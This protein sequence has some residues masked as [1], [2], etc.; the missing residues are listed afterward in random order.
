MVVSK[1]LGPGPTAERNLSGRKR[2][3]CL[4]VKD[5]VRF[6]LNVFIREYFDGKDMPAID[7]RL[8]HRINN[9]HMQALIQF[10]ASGVESAGKKHFFKVF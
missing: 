6:F 2:L 3:H 4:I 9:R 8:A 1:Q 7:E 5:H 10:H